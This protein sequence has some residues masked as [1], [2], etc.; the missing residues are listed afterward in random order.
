MWIAAHNF[1]RVI[2][3]RRIGEIDIVAQDLQDTFRRKRSANKGPKRIKPLAGFVFIV[4]FLPVSIGG[5]YSFET[6]DINVES[7][8]D[9]S[10]PE[11][12][13]FF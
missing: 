11:S 3:F 9:K 6:D 1:G 10:L 13:P 7:T 12:D 4:D 8:V 2:L 5:F